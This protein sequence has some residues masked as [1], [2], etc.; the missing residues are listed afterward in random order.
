MS[1][2][3]VT[4]EVFLWLMTGSMSEYVDDDG[5]WA[6]QF[7]VTNHVA[8]QVCKLWSTVCL[9]YS[10]TSTASPMNITKLPEREPLPA[11]VTTAFADMPT[12]YRSKVRRAARRFIRYLRS[13]T[14]AFPCPFGM[15]LFLS[16][17]VCLSMSFHGLLRVY[18]IEPAVL[19]RMRKTLG[20]ITLASVL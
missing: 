16:C 2:D 9:V 13:P 10:R 20:N 7:I 1:L 5:H 15:H 8:A 11:P 3:F 4:E 19:I 17:L 6:S 14:F 18:S 12:S